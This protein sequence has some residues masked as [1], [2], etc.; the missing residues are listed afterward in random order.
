MPAAAL[1]RITRAQGI[2]RRPPARTRPW[3]EAPHIVFAIY[4]RMPHRP[5]ARHDPDGASGHYDRGP[6][7][8]A[9]APCESA[10]RQCVALPCRASPRVLTKGYWRYQRAKQPESRTRPNRTNLGSDTLLAFFV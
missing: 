5:R 9:A 4:P 1:E 10:V 2:F 6:L 8:R 3:L 7:R